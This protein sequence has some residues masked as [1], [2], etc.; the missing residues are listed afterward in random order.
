MT[1]SKTEKIY[2]S[3]KTKASLQP[4]QINLLA[5]VIEADLHLTL[6]I[7][8]IKKKNHLMADF[9]ILAGLPHDNELPEMYVLDQLSTGIL[10]PGWGKEHTLL[11]QMPIPLS[12]HHTQNAQGKSCLGKVYGESSE[13]LPPLVSH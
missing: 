2:V 7:N 4:P 13:A 8:L 11:A 6:Q 3:I 1:G 12:C 10:R 5:A 9:S